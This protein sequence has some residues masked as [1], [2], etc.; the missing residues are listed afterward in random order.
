MDL[1]S[2]FKLEM[3]NSFINLLSSNVILNGFENDILGMPPWRR[4]APKTEKSAVIPFISRILNAHKH[5]DVIE[6]S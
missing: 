3:G 5:S 2:A 6:N 1:L 4:D